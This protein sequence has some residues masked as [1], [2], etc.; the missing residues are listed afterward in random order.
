[1]SSGTE[2]RDG[3][4]FAP[5]P[6]GKKKIS[7]LRIERVAISHMGGVG[8]RLQGTDS[9]DG[10]IVGSYVRGCD[11]ANCRDH[12]ILLEFAYQTLLSRCRFAANGDEGVAA[13]SFSQA[14]LQT[15]TFDANKSKPGTSAK[16]DLSIEQCSLARVDAC[17]FKNFGVPANS[18]AIYMDACGGVGSVGACVFETGNIG[19]EVVTVLAANGAILVLPNRF[20]DVDTA[21]KLGDGVIAC[22]VLPQFNA[23]GTAVIRLPA[24][25]N[26]AP[27]AVASLADSAG[28]GGLSGLLIPSLTVTPNES[29]PAT[30][31]Q[32][33][34]LF[35][36]NSGT[37]M[38]RA[39][40]D[41]A[42]K[43]V[44]AI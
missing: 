41:G 12:G 43:D 1:M 40:V 32:G 25:V 6:P 34:M 24:L 20:K 10:A 4:R 22:T 8:V 15:C 28:S 29:D 27:I 23:S 44:S 31:V 7:M 26:D 13:R 16:A 37:P 33:G 14:V 38:L 11:I 18:R 36:R 42:W 5:D 35:Y 3:I 19:L 30:N 9:G 17:T 39:F 21:I 2:G